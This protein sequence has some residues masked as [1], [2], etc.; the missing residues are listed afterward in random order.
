MKSC[1]SLYKI[2]VTSPLGRLVLYNLTAASAIVTLPREFDKLTI[3]LPADRSRKVI[4]T[5]LKYY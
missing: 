3:I 1:V 2:G 4:Q 5:P